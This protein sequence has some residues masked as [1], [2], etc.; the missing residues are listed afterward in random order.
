[1]PAAFKTDEAS[2]SEAL[3]H[4]LKKLESVPLHDVYS[5]ND[6][7]WHTAA[8]FDVCQTALEAALAGSNWRGAAGRSRAFYDGQEASRQGRAD[9][10]CPFPISSSDALDWRAGMVTV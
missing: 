10:D 9:A 4:L 6:A 8:Q 1:M 2:V 5:I 3:A 7:T